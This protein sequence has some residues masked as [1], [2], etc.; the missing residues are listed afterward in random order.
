MEALLQG[1]GT[2][3]HPRLHATKRVRGEDSV[4]G[5]RRAN[6]R[7][8]GLPGPSGIKVGPLCVR[9]FAHPLRPLSVE[10]QSSI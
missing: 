8:F 9:A 2:L 7:L 10:M 6:G 5:L 3:L 1:R 4:F